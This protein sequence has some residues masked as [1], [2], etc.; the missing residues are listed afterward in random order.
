VWYACETTRSNRVLTVVT[1]VFSSLFIQRKY[2]S[3]LVGDGELTEL[4]TRKMFGSQLWEVVLSTPSR[5]G[6]RLLLIAK[7]R[8]DTKDAAST[9]ELANF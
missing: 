5:Q 3:E 1:G 7:W 8:A 6:V 2:D 9:D 4:K